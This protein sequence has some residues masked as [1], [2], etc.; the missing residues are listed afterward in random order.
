[1]EYQNDHTDKLVILYVEGLHLDTVIL[2]NSKK[3][4][5]IPTDIGFNMLV[6]GVSVR[7]CGRV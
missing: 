2:F 1:M 4:L 6:E 3:L 7:E 5:D